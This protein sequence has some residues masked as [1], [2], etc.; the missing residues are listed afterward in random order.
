MKK[1]PQAN[2]KERFEDK[3]SL[4]SAVKDLASGDLWIDRVNEGKGLD[5]VSNKKLLRLHDTL[6][7]V[8][9]KFGS[10]S[11]LIEAIIKL[12]GRQKDADYSKHFEGWSTP[13]LFDR[14]QALAKKAD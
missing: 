7:Q 14:H 10:R 13:R 9:E 6:S 1:S 11:A 2:V 4:V 3:A 8:K 12:E 5:R